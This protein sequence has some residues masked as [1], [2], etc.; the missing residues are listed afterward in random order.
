MLLLKIQTC[1]STKLQPISCL[2]TT[3][4]L[5]FNEHTLS[6]FCLWLM[7]LWLCNPIFS[8]KD[9]NFNRNR[10]HLSQA[11]AC[12]SCWWWQLST[13]KMSVCLGSSSSAMTVFL[14]PHISISCVFTISPH[15][16]GVSWPWFP[17]WKCLY[18]F[19][20]DN[21][22]CFMYF[23]GKCPIIL[24][25]WNEKKNCMVIILKLHKLQLE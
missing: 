19:T 2:T 25:P 14:L 7:D 12:Y 17:Q 11:W 22:E 24:L 10:Q 9:W 13:I 16:S 18:S 3:T 21:W 15:T 6:T 20:Q 1:M 23:L 5:F 8:Q 4:L